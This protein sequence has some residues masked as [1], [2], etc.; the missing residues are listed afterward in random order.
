MSIWKRVRDLVTAHAYDVLEKLEKPERMVKQ[1]IR[2]LEQEWMQ[3]EQALARQMVL[4]KKQES[5][6]RDI[7]E[8]IAKRERQAKLAVETG[9]DAIARL[10]L[11]DKLLLEKK[12]QAYRKQLETI[13]QQTEILAEQ[14]KD[15]R[16]TYEELKNKQFALLTRLHAARSIQSLDDTLASAHAEGVKKKFA[17]LE[18][19]VLW[20]EMEAQARREGHAFSPSLDSRLRDQHLQEEVEQALEKLKREA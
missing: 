15:L 8:A 6:I 9:E 3:A 4:K 7:E 13:E 2:E 11:Q 20:M 16:E 12:E 1:Y 17:R 5:L 14:L 10:A 18:E 19:R